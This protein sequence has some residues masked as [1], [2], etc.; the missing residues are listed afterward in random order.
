MKTITGNLIDLAEAGE[1]HLIVHG[2]N[3]WNT[4]QSGIARE[5]RAR[6]PEAYEVDCATTAGDYNKLGNYTVMLGK[7]FN[8]VN[9]YTQY[10]FNSGG[11]RNDV[12]EYVS[13]AMI[14]QKLAHNYPMC[15]FGFPLIGQG[16]AGGDPVKIMALLE[17]FSQQI[18]GSVTIVLFGG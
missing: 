18:E 1:F 17:D 10:G 15:N 14:L 16:L 3:C 4:M 2:A 5:I 7:Q 8:V 12:F 9:A 6:Y 11:T 13:F